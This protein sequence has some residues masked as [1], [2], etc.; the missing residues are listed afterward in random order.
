[1]GN[2]SIRYIVSDVDAAVAFYTK[3]FEFE[4][5]MRPA[6][7]FA[8]LKRDNLQLLLNVPGAG[9][10]GATMPDG[11]VPKP[12]GWNRFRL[13]F[14]DLESLVLSLKSKGEKFRSEIIE[15]NGGKQILIDD[16]SGNAIELFEPR[17][18]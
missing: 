3:L 5:E 8:A 4:V 2:V 12:G 15:G 14:Q 10:A 16:P 1:M 6:P 18:R 17:K 7:G 9:G 13:E 11:T